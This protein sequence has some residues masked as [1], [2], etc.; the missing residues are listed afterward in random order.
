MGGAFDDR[1]AEPSGGGLVPA[2]DVDSM[3]DWA[4]L[5][6][7]RAREE[8]VAL[9][10]EG[11]LLTDLM[12]HVLQTGL[13]VEMTDHLG[14]GP[15][16]RGVREGGNA[17][18]GAYD[19]T[20]ITEIGP[21]ELRVPR[22]RAGTFE[23]VTVPKYQRRLDGLSGNVISLYA[24]GLTTG[25]IQQHLAEIYG[26]EVSRE[27]ISKIT[28]QI[29]DDMVAWQNRP[30]DPVYAVLV[31]DCLVIKVR[32]SQVANRP[33]YVALGVNLDGERDVL[34]L[35]LG[36]SG[37][38]GAKQWATMLTELRNRGLQDALIVCCD[39]LKGLPESIRTTWP[40]ATVQT[41]VVHMV[42]NS[43]RYASRKH[44]QRITGQMREIY[45][46][47]TVEAAETRFA[48]FADEWRPLYPAMINAWESV[49]EEFV[50]FLAFPIELRKL[51]YTTNS[52]ESL[53]ARFRRAVRHRGHFPT[54]QAA[55]KVLFL[56]ATQ[57]RK[58]RQ[59]M[60]GR[61]NGWKSILNTPHVH[62]GDRITG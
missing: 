18:N 50:P 21:V 2:G 36:P 13:D 34:G 44:W 11:G 20:V 12:Q 60:T 47:P 26:T 55:L 31:I 46:A 53:N 30:L 25:D 39:G 14:Y 15:Y 51:V 23:P 6:V 58:N 45:T 61:I 52:V 5:L 17:R 40:E 4:A 59:D 48:E 38:E 49:W 37:G 41:C 35:W 8:G 3:R 42:R 32:G 9:T 19:K 54:E 29:V 27:T 28:D 16:E 24:K 7:A 43:L 62:Y 1:S 33:V 56:V 10:G 57:T 22:D